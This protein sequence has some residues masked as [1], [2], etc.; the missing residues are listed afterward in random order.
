MSGPAQPPPETT[1]G[2][3]LPHEHAALP[4]W[5]K[6]GDWTPTPNAVYRKLCFCFPPVVYQLFQAIGA[7]TYGTSERVLDKHRKPIMRE[8]IGAD[9]KPKQ[10]AMCVRKEWSDK[11]DEQWAEELNRSVNS[12]TSAQIILTDPR[13]GLTERRKDPGDARKRQYR[14]NLDA[15]RAF[16]PLKAKAALEADAA[17]AAKKAAESGSASVDARQ[18]ISAFRTALPAEPLVLLAGERSRPFVLTPKLAVSVSNYEDGRGAQVLIEIA[19]RGTVAVCARFLDEG[20]IDFAICEPKPEGEETAKPEKQ[21]TVQNEQVSS[22]VSPIYWGDSATPP[23]E[24]KPKVSPLDW[25]DSAP[26]L[27]AAPPGGFERFIDLVQALG[28]RLPG[29]PR[30]SLPLLG[31]QFSR[32]EAAGIS[33][34]AFEVSWREKLPR[35][36][37]FK[38]VSW[39]IDDLIADSTRARATPPPAA[40]AAQSQGSVPEADSGPELAEAYEAYTAAA[41]DAAFEELP[42]ADRDRLLKAARKELAGKFAAWKLWDEGARIKLALRSARQN[43]GIRV[44]TFAEFCA[45]A[46]PPGREA[47]GGPHAD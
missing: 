26:P 2:P 3:A 46:S 39:V 13:W 34:S 28:D 38:S 40:P 21:P 17:A 27:P 8:V 29:R 45:R 32:L 5:C 44:L 42:V 10:E 47:R 6:K 14:N 9:G 23:A 35:L 25:G 24:E 37:T 11:T 12:I 4:G 36:K 18:G 20:R 7:S 15:L 1:Y 33:V 22:K 43:A 41:L 16:D 30:A 31:K 19:G